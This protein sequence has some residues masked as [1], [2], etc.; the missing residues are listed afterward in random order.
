MQVVGNG[1]F[2]LLND[3]EHVEL[4]D[5]ASRLNLPIAS[6]PTTADPVVPVLTTGSIGATEVTVSGD[7]DSARLSDLLPATITQ[8]DDGGFA[9]SGPGALSISL[10]GYGLTYAN[11][12]LSAG[13]ISRVGF[14][15]VQAGHTNLVFSAHDIAFS[16]WS[17]A[18]FETWLIR[19]D[20]P[21]AFQTLLA[22]NDVIS[23]GTG[24]DLIR[25]YAGGDFIQGL[26]GADTVFGGL[27]DDV[28]YAS[29]R[30]SWVPVGA[31]MG[32]YLR[33]DEGDDYIVGGA[34]FDNI[35]G[36]MGR[37]TESGG[38]GNDWVVG[39]KDDDFLSGD[40]GA[41]IVNGN[42][43]ND[44]CVGGL[45]D[46]SVRGGQADDMIY[47]GAGNDWLSGDLGNDTESGGAGADIFRVFTGDGIDRVTDFNAAEGDRVQ[48]DPGT[49]YTVRQAGADTIVDLGSS[50]Q[51]I[52]VGVQIATLPAGWIFSA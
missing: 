35:N 40:A 15:D 37:D 7:M 2:L 38:A 14:T 20:A 45:G 51:L 50:S 12:Q 13:T 9:A 30:S 24:A 17:A 25:G 39:G 31:A 28:I 6:D 3:Q 21:T 49:P 22:G 10:D 29:A 23:G 27:G 1:R 33:G 5:L 48:F 52:L 18:Q 11:N 46:D 41:D 42:L 47:G 32:T 16:N 4:I 43:G 19:N 8:A 36:N 44:T 34:G 26:G